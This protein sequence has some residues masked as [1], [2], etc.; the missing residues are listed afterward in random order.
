MKAVS[1]MPPVLY[2]HLAAKRARCYIYN[3][4]NSGAYG[5][6]DLNEDEIKKLNSQIQAHD[7]LKN[8]LFFV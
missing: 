1:V 6:R 7:N 2:A 3:H 8:T 5:D 4:S